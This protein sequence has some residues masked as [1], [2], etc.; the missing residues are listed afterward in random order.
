M[1]GHR[2]NDP[3]AVARKPTVFGMQGLPLQCELQEV[4]PEKQ[5]DPPNICLAGKCFLLDTRLNDL[6]FIVQERPDDQFIDNIVYNDK[7]TLYCNC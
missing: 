2:P 3:N 5:Q 4:L 1:C 7:S 6:G